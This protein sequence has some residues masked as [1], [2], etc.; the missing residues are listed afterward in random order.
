MPPLEGIRSRAGS[1]GRSPLPRPMNKNQ[2][3]QRNPLRAQTGGKSLKKHEKRMNAEVVNRKSVC[4]GPGGGHTEVRRAA[5]AG[6]ARRGT[7]A[8]SYRDGSGTI[9]GRF[10]GVLAAEAPKDRAGD[11]G[12]GAEPPWASAPGGS[13]G[14]RAGPPRPL[15]DGPVGLPGFAPAPNRGWAVGPPRPLKKG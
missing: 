2:L 1:G 4:G 5:R 15:E 13:P 9:R 7:L 10:E 11:P 12:D 14:R 3:R 8:G 6:C